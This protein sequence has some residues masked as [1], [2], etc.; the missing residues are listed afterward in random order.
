MGIGVAF[1]AAPSIF[2]ELSAFDLNIIFKKWLVIFVL[3]GVKSLL[4]DI[5]VI[6]FKVCSIGFKA[7]IS[8][9]PAL[10]PSQDI[11]IKYCKTL[12]GLSEY[13]SLNELSPAVL[14]S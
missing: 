4:A 3:G 8:G 11:V 10:D 9:S 14:I 7:I 6:S 5:T 2:K 1:G 12:M 13:I